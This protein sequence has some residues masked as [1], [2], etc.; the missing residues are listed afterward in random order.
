M[1]QV[2]SEGFNSEM[3]AVAAHPGSQPLVL[4]QIVECSREFGCRRD[5]FC[6]DTAGLLLVVA[7]SDRGFVLIPVLEQGMVLS[8]HHL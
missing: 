4:V 2:P 5:N 7:I 8:K 1:D 3:G 6:R